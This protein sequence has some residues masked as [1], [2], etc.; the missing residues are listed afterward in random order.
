MPSASP[1][2]P[3][4]QAPSPRPV[5]R[6]P[7][8]P[9]RRRARKISYRPGR[10][11]RTRVLR[12][13]ARHLVNRFSYGITPAAGG[14]GPGRRRPPRLVRPPA[15]H[16]VRRQRGQPLR[17]V[18]GPAPRPRRPV[19]PHHRRRARRLGGHVGLR[20]PHDDA[21]DD[22]AAPGARGDD[23]VLGEPLPRR[24]RTPT[25]SSSTGSTYGE[26]VR[27]HAL[28]RF[29]DLLQATVLHPAMLMFLGAATSTKAHPNENLG[30]ELLELH[31]VGH[32]QLRRG[33]RQ[34]LGPDPDRQPGRPL[35]DLGRRPTS[36][37]TTGPGRCR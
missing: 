23:G 32:R 10:Y 36:P 22:L 33:R 3:P 16:G 37:R 11:P 29:D 4:L 2:E 26:V 28:G 6:S 7:P 8:R 21:P 30:R 18:A 25:T 20:Q 31:T 1:A 12:E 27:R 34:E 19:D 9:S 35:Q 17:L 5:P 15:R 24:R 14:G 13:P